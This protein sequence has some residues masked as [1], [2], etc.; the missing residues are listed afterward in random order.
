M[1]I[2]TALARNSSLNTLLMRASPAPLG[3]SSTSPRS[4]AAGAS[5][6]TRAPLF[7]RKATSNRESASRS[8]SRAMCPTSVASLRT[9]L[10]RAGT[11]KNRSRTSMV[12]PAGCAAGLHRRDAAAIHIDFRCVVCASAAAR[13]GAGA[14]PS[15][16][17]AAPRRENR[18][19]QRTRDRPARRSCWWRDAR[20]RAAIRP[21]ECRGHRRGCG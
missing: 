21:P 19:S 1:F 17:R 6:S 13:R 8:T 9:N 15:R 10:R 7:N 12:V 14:R 20:S 2:G 3:M 16:W 4:T 11:L 18:A 5:S